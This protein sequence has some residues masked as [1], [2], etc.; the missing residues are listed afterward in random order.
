M[1]LSRA[2]PAPGHVIPRFRR[3]KAAPLVIR[4]R[5][6]I[7]RRVA[8]SCTREIEEPHTVDVR[9]VPRPDLSGR[10]ISHTASEILID[11]CSWLGAWWCAGGDKA[12][13]PHPPM[14]A[15]TCR[16]ASC[17]SRQPAGPLSI[18]NRWRETPG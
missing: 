16:L 5:P 17:A 13:Y 9:N 12:R 4:N 2:Y 3:K 11:L 18:A 6:L 1:R 7:P 10:V 14:S 15:L 8:Q